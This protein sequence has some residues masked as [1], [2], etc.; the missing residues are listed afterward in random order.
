MKETSKSVIPWGR[1]IDISVEVYRE[2]TWESGAKVR[3]DAPKTLLISDNGHRVGAADGSHYVPY[4]WIHL[5]WLNKDDRKHQFYY[6]RQ[7]K[8]KGTQPSK[9]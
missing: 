5:Y 9:A 8:E 7:V 4:G 2:Y 6:Q 3:I 1:E